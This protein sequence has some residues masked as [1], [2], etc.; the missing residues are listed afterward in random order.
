ME[1][2]IRTNFDEATGYEYL[3][4]CVT[5]AVLAPID[6]NATEKKHEFDDSAHPMI[7]VIYLDDV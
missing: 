7:L 1:T 6:P 3:V 5:Y 4:S 2:K